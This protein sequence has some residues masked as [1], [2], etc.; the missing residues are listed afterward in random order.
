MGIL[1]L[2]FIL[3]SGLLLTA[4]AS[5]GLA[6]SCMLIAPDAAPER[7]RLETIPRLITDTYRIN[8]VQGSGASSPLMGTTVTVEGIVIGDFQ[9][10][11]ADVSRTLRGFY[12]Q[13]EAEDSDSDPITSEGVFIFDGDAPVV[14]VNVGDKVRVTGS[15][16][17]FFGQTEINAV[18]VA[19]SGSGAVNATEV[20]L[21]AIS[22]ISNTDG[23]LIPDLE[24]YEGMLVTFPAPL[25]IT[26]LF[27]LERFGAFQ[28]SQGGRLFQFTNQNEPSVVGYAAYLEALARRTITVDDGLSE[29][30]PDPIIYP[31]GT[32][33]SGDSLRLGHSVTGLTGALR[34][35]RG[36]GG[37]GPA[38]Y[39]LLPTIDPIF[40]ATNPRPVTPTE[41]GGTLK[42]ASFNLLNFFTML[43]DGQN[44]ARGADSEVEFDRQLEKLITTLVGL[45]ADIVGLIELE[46]NYAASQD[47]AIATLV[48]A[49][50][51]RTGGEVYAFVDPGA[52]STGSDAIA[53][54]F[55]Y[56]TDK[57]SV[58]A[59]TTVESLPLLASRPP[60]AV[61]FREKD[62]GEIVTIVLN[63]FKSKAPSSLDDDEND[64]NGD[65]LCDLPDDPNC[66]QLDG[67]GYWNLRRTQMAEALIDWLASDPTGSGD[68][69]FLIIGDL[70]AYPQ[71]DPIKILEQE[72]TNLFKTFSHSAPYTFVFE[73]QAGLLDYGFASTSLAEQATGMTTWPINADEP[74]VLDYNLEDGRNATL[75]DGAL[76]F[77]AADHDPLLIGLA[78]GPSVVQA[79]PVY[80]PL[81]TK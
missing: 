62:S 24:R 44:G 36:S 22:V 35:G 7:G 34:Y 9:A 74:P 81:V 42:V 78:L 47:S 61:T 65:G 59:G 69:D 71:E 33:D 11:D 6:Y 31:D 70:N 3:F 77:R 73:G 5:N 30:N 66:N 48:G 79:G 29:L 52:A 54:G 18:Q 40:V 68:P 17:E 13:E 58:A 51:G 43:D 37:S 1:I 15:V 8:A 60:L 16:T 80:L 72:Y 4:L 46:N 38:T 64:G 41:V 26:D 49:L 21:P 19:I 75:F 45:D 2:Q 39:R 12:L 53:L 28:A 63:H 27:N 50:N 10:G 56:K 23:R 76:P 57:V 55:I 32:L 25:T 20:Q 67:Q 14:D